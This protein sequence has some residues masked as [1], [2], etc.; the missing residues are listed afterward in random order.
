MGGAPDI[1]ADDF[2]AVLGV[3]RTAS[4]DEIKRAYL[5]LVREY[6]PERAQEVFKRIREAYETLSDPTTRGQYDTRLDPRITGL[7]NQA[8]E[9]MQAKDYPRAEQ[10][11]KQA[12]LEAPQLAWVRNLLGICFLYQKRPQDA[13]AQYERLLQQPTSDPS[14]H[15][16][17]AHA[18]GSLQRYA[19]AEAQFRLAMSVAGDRGFEYGLSLLDMVADLGAVDRAD[20]LA[21]DLVAAAPK[22]SIAAA[23]YGSK[24][25]EFAVRGNRRPTIPSLL[26]R[27]TQG[28]ETDEEKSIVAGALGNLGSR[29]IAAE[30]FDVAEQ[31]ARTAGRVQPQDPGLDALEQAG[32][33]LHRNNF[34]A[35]SR[36]LRTHVSF[37][38]GGVVQKLKPWIEQ[39]CATHAVYNGMRPL[40]S[41]PSSSKFYGIGAT[42]FGERD[43]D[44]QTKS[45]VVTQYFT[46]FF[47]PLF[48]VACYRVRP[49][50][51]V[52]YYL[53]QVPLKRYQKAHLWAAVGGIALWVVIGSL[54]QPASES[55]FSSG[56]A[57]EAGIPLFQETR[58]DGELVETT[59]S[60][61]PVRAPMRM[62]FTE[63]RTSGRGYLSVFRPLS[64]SGPCQVRAR[65]DSVFIQVL[66]GN[67]TFTYLGAQRGDT[68]A[69]IYRMN[70]RE[71]RRPHGSWRAWLV[72]GTQVPTPLDPW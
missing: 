34:D 25:I 63:L 20:R 29:L 3:A 21:Q 30:L 26:L 72:S 18:Y 28:L 42:L 17:L 38:P 50:G 14:V 36:L 44:E 6:T 9:A 41:P 55:V 40:S 65:D 15:A 51:G 60:Q 4:P 39:Y 27:M 23:A 62:L 46:V 70:G 54:S 32:R 22:G 71:T 57:A 5:A 35:V 43:Y 45:H 47:I 48:P 66:S 69:G 61:G 58:Y 1:H 19:D 37:A 68:M 67:D 53:G 33:L 12:L 8:S 31:V 7:L 10:C 52:Q 11:Y 24:Q 49:A 64:G 2:Y 13:I 56:P 16:N 59:D